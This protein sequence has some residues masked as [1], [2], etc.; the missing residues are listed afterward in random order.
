[1]TDILALRELLL[2]N[3]V[4][5][6]VRREALEALRNHERLGGINEAGIKIITVDEIDEKGANQ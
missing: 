3:R 1:V 6:T 2:D 4:S 5:E